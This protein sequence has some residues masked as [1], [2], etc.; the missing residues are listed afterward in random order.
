MKYIYVLMV[1]FAGLCLSCSRPNVD[2]VLVEGGLVQGVP[3]EVNADVIVFKGIPFAAPPVGELRWRRPQP[4]V[5]WEGVLVAD[6]Y[7]KICPQVLTRPLESYPE[8]YRIL[9][10]EHDED[11]L[12]LNVWAPANTVGDPDAKL[13]VMFWIHGGAYRTG[14]GITMSTDGDAWAQHG[15]ILVTI[16]YRLNVLGFL[17]HPALTAESGKSGN[18]GLYDQVAALK[19]TYENIGQFGGDPDNITIAGQSA[20]AR[21]VKY[22][23]TSPL[24]KPY[25]SKAIVESGGGLIPRPETWPE[26]RPQSLLDAAG[27]AYFSSG[28]FETLAQMRA[29]SYED[30]IQGCEGQFAASAHPDGE[31]LITEFDQVVYEGTVAD[32]P[33]LIGYNDAEPQ[34]FEPVHNFCRQRAAS[35]SQPVYE[36]MFCRTPGKSGGCPHSVCVQY[37]GQKG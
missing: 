22:L 10:T 27:A 19:W 14:S 3:S 34:M 30:I 24:A 6:H 26:A 11:C 1:L 35:G 23:S 28:G 12:Y 37:A 8:K 15:V 36:Y 2:T 17:N 18:Y 9:Y 25:I 21:S 16:N 7:K 31:I 4:V 29:A 33:F 20:G 13:P 5:P 32:I